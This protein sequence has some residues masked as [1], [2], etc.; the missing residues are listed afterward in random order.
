MMLKAADVA[1]QL[2]I[3]PRAV[4][5]LADARRLACYRVGTGSG[6]VRFAQTDVDAY[7]AAGCSTKDVRML[8]AADLRK[9]AKLRAAACSDGDP[10][11]SPPLTPEQQAIAESRFRRMTPPPWADKRA[12]QEVYDEARRKTTETGESHHVDHI[13]PL[14]GVFVSGL[15]V[16]SNLRVIPRRENITKSNKVEEC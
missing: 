9:Y 3:S 13:V 14:L 2:G 5:D 8:P 7:K 12:I 11:D 15:H 10:I 1:A 16:E 6:A 4:Y